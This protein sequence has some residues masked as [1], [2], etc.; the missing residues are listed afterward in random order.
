MWGS[1]YSE[2]QFASFDFHIGRGATV[3]S[4]HNS[5]SPP[6][7]KRFFS[8]IPL[9]WR[10]V[11]ILKAWCIV[12]S[13][14][15]FHFLLFL[16]SLF[17][18]ADGPSCVSVLCLF[19]LGRL[20]GPLLHPNLSHH[21]QRWPSETRQPDFPRI[22]TTSAG[23][24]SRGPSSCGQGAHPFPQRQCFPRRNSVGA[25]LGIDEPSIPRGVQSATRSSSHAVCLLPLPS[26]LWVFF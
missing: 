18:S 5:K 2:C 15:L 20:P 16:I 3:E 10:E 6:K 25:L 11:F 22:C 17:N 13:L 1:R 23:K 14:F 8:H 4:H 7:G 19:P 21:D 26:P 9:R 12:P 24:A